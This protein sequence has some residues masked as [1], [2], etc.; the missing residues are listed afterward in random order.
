MDGQGGVTTSRIHR[1]TLRC[2]VL[3]GLKLIGGFAVCRALSTGALR[4]LGY[5]GIS[6]A[7]EHLFNSY[8][9]MRPELF[10]DRMQRMVAAGYRVLPLAEAV[11]VLRAGALPHGAVVLTFDDVWYGVYR[12]A[13]P[14]LAELKLPATLYVTTSSAERRV[15]VFH[16]ALQYLFWGTPALNLDLSAL[17]CGLHGRYDLTDSGQRQ[18]VTEVLLAHGYALPSPEQ[19]HALL[20]DLAQTLRMDPTLLAER[21]VCS[22]MSLEEIAEAAAAGFDIQLH[23]HRHTLSTSDRAAVVRE[24]TDNRAALSRVLPGPWTHF[25]YPSGVYHPRVWPWLKELGIETATTIRHGFNYRT[26]NPLELFRFLDGDNVAPVEFDAE[27]AGALELFRRTSGAL[28]RRVH[29][30]PPDGA[31]GG[32]G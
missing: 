4:I 25:C 17:G 18:A 5:H 22:L 24:I 13:L 30:D 19:R 1:R 20:L 26:G 11:H 6:L 23:T 14:V 9:F 28:L 2:K 10:R 7:D 8:L 27:L 12:H 3:G 32:A 16:I 29:Q 21:R 15:A 31:Y